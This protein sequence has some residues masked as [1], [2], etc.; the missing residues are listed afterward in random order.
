MKKQQ[1]IQLFSFMF[2]ITFIVSS[3]VF[4]LGNAYKEER[5]NRINEETIIADEIGNV[6]ETFYSKETELNNFRADL[7]E[8]IS[9]SAAY[10]ANMPVNYDDIFTGFDSY[11]VQVGEIEDISVYL[12]EKCKKTYSIL[13][14]NNKCNA[15]Y[16]NLEKTI[17]LF[18]GEVD[19]FNA[20]IDEYN[21]WIV[22]ENENPLTINK[23]EELDKY[24]SK[25]YDAYVDLNNDGTYLEK[26]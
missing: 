26:K 8:K 13:E 1:Y 24:V 7:T 9:D 22:E 14:A 11:E 2:G 20:K 21:K 16:I 18:V 15:Y 10:Y 4:T 25:K 23:Y 6:Y 3:I 12:K 5:K 17:N 19:Y